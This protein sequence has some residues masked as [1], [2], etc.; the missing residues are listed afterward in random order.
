M[1]VLHTIHPTGEY[2]ELVQNVHSFEHSDLGKA[3]RDINVLDED[4]EY[5]DDTNVTEHGIF[6][7]AEDIVESYII[8][9]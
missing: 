7:T 6:T 5:G 1:R 2:T 3:Y 9:G 8:I 4:F